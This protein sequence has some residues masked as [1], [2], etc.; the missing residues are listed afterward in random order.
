MVNKDIQYIFFAPTTTLSR[1]DVSRPTS[2]LQLIFT[3][4]SASV[5]DDDDDEG[6][7]LTSL[8]MTTW[9][10]VGADKPSSLSVDTR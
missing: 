7:L 9:S 2:C 8:F 3:V 10:T 4:W 6:G 5:E 1:L